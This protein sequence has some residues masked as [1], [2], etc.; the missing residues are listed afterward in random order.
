MFCLYFSAVN[1]SESYAYKDSAVLVLE[2]FNYGVF[3]CFFLR[4]EY[5]RYPPT[6]KPPAKVVAKIN[7]LFQD[8]SFA[9]LILYTISLFLLTIVFFSL[10]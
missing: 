4:F 6:I 9:N 5:I 1:S 7:L 2:Y 3:A 8:L 10:G